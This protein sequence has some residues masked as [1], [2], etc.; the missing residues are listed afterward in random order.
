MDFNVKYSI[1]SNKEI[2]VN[3]FIVDNKVIST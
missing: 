2:Y 1:Q 3:I